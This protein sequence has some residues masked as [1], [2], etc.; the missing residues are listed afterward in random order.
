M[1]HLL[2][3]LHLYHLIFYVSEMAGQSSLLKDQ[4]E[5]QDR[6]KCEGST[7]LQLNAGYFLLHLLN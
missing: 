4:T 3:L 1:S 2:Q 5:A 6:E 7:Y